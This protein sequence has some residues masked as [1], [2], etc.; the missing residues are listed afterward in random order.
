MANMDISR[1]LIGPPDSARDA[2]DR[3]V[4]RSVEKGV[5]RLGRNTQLVTT[6][7]IEPLR[8]LRLCRARPRP[9]SQ[10]LHDR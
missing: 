5:I 8:D 4:M 7:V 9:T 6:I 2:A 1:E 3:P 10:R